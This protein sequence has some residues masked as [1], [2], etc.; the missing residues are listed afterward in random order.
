[1]IKQ[2]NNSV[3]IYLLFPA[4]TMLLGWGLRGYI[5][6]GPFGAMI[7]GAMLALSMALLLKLSAETTAVL[8]VLSAIGIG[9]GGEMTYGQTLGFLRSPETMW[10]G[11]LGITVK[12]AIWGLLGGI[13]LS[14][15]F[16]YRKMSGRTL[17]ITFL[18]L[19]AGM[20]A[21]FKLIN[22]PMLIY[23]SYPEEPRPESWGALLVAAIVLWVYL[24]KKLEAADFKILQRM[25]IAGLISGGLGFGLGGF[26]MV[27]GNQLPADPAFYHCLKVLDWWKCMEFTFGFLLGAGFGLATWYSRREIVALDPP[28][29]AKPAFAS[30]KAWK[31]ITFLFVLAF[32]IFWLIPNFLDPVVDQNYEQ[33]R[34]VWPNGIDLA[35]MVSNF[36][37][38]GLLMVWA[39]IRFPWLAWQI[40]ITMTFCYTSIDLVQDFFPETTANSPFTARFALIFGMT[41]IVALL[42]AYFQRKK[43]LIRNMFL[44]LTAACMVVAYLRW[45]FFG[46]LDKLS[47]LPLC[48]VLSNY[49]FVHLIFTL[50]ALYMVWVAVRKL[51]PAS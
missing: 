30:G 51:Q 43:Y 10:W 16:F 13:V 6:G 45:G 33:G 42:T 24:K 47:G 48:E 37:F 9:L 44:L 36:A 22:Q 38:F 18:L 12:G 15:G 20:L 28:P 23:F 3:W 29:A 32:L 41:L 25:A 21:G 8:V 40:G 1:M 4:V 17:I 46:Q 34:F 7:P 5:G 31:E 2:N 11:T 19:L 50:S 27:L 39:V 35:K 26:W 49:F 14:L